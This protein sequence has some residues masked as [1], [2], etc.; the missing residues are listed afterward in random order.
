MKKH[1]SITLIF[2]LAAALWPA[3]SSVASAETELPAVAA[4]AVAALCAKT[5]DN[6]TVHLTSGSG[7]KVIYF[8]SAV[9]PCVRSCET[10]SLNPAAEKYKGQVTVYA[11]ASGRFEN[12]LDKTK[13]E[14]IIATHHLSFPV[15][16]DPDHQVA[17][18][19][20]AMVT[21]ECYIIDPNNNVVFAG[22]PDD[23]RAYLDNTG[24]V[25]F[26]HAYLNTALAQALAG[27]PITQPVNKSFG[28][29][30]GK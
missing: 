27:Q 2:A 14:Q 28:C 3:V 8:W 4:S 18:A 11:V 19:L 23:S 20:G 22:M 24:K 17:D 5:L 10:L 30:I 16:M 25:G 1:D 7:W 6:Q 29:L 12:T 15:L 13:L 26:T 21:P 9:C